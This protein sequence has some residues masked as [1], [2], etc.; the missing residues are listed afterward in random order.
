MRTL[1]KTSKLALSKLSSWSKGVK[2]EKLSIIPEGLRKMTNI[3]HCTGLDP[4]TENKAV[5]KDYR[6][7]NWIS[8]MT[9][10]LYWLINFVQ[11]TILT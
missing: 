3:V 5:S 2:S 1:H 11:C 7:L 6:T 10:Y 4:G 8:L 9:H